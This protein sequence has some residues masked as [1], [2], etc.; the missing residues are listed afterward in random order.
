MIAYTLTNNT[1]TIVLKNKVHT[2]NKEQP[3]WEKVMTAIQNNDE[4][5]LLRCLNTET[6]INSF[7]EGNVTIKDNVVYYKNTKLDNYVVSKVVDFAANK[8][9]L[10]PIL[11]FINNLMKNP[12]RRTVQ[13]LYKFLEHKNMPITP[14][15]NFLAYK[16]VQ[17][18]FF[19]ITSGSAVVIKGT[20]KEGHIYNG[21]GEEIEVERNSVCDDSAIPCSSGLHAGSLR[22]AS[23]FG[24]SGTVIIVEINPSDVVS[25]PTDSN[26]EKLR[27]CKYKVVGI[28]DGPLDNHYNDKYPS[29]QPL[30]G[31]DENSSC[32]DDENYGTTYEDSDD[33]EDSENDE[34]NCGD[35]NCKSCNP[36]E[37]SIPKGFKTFKELFEQNNTEQNKPTENISRT[38][39]INAWNEWLKAFE[40]AQQNVASNTPINNYNQA[41]N[42]F[43]SKLEKNIPVYQAKAEKSK[44]QL[45]N[46]ANE[47]ILKLKEAIEN[48]FTPKK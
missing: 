23:K 5:L 14:D 12:S 36:P 28:Y 46:I 40:Q 13:E 4:D 42:D 7:T 19:S 44:E 25:V 32:D 47:A 11:R 41:L 6:A 15:G 27:A 3:Q 45:Q 9:P 43:L 20:V 21:V 2:I 30:D 29:Q 24:A 16:G 33:I 34:P 17:S 22:Y 1:L 26:N 39:H 35:P 38:P 31:P 18:N 10:Q 37:Q 48:K 8:L